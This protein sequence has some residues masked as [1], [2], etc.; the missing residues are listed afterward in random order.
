MDLLSATHEIENVLISIYPNPAIDILNIDVL[1]HLSYRVKLYDLN[2]KLI[3]S[4]E[5]KNKIR[6]DLIS[7]GIYLLELQDLKSGHKI[8]EKIEITR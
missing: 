3:S 5:N 8:V 4:S 7:A 1:G 2:G 6:L